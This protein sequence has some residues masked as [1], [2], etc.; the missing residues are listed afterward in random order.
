MRMAKLSPSWGYARIQGAMANLGHKIAPNTVKRL[1]KEHGIEP[2]PFR[3]RR[4]TWA[5]FLR[6][7]WDTLPIS[8]PP[9]S[10]LPAGLVTFY[11]LFA[12]Q[13]K[14]RWVH[15]SIPTPNPDRVFMKQVALDLAA[16][17]DSFLRG[18]SHL[19]I[20]RDSKYTTEFR[21]VLKENDVDIVPIP[22]K[23]PNCNPHA[24]R[25]VRSV[26]QEYASIF[27]LD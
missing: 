24:E 3:R 27:A 20:D 4:T 18:Y 9:K 13:L 5:Q 16:F 26:K 8:S 12:I 14:T 19:I 10:G 11:V 22:T 17:D 25:F 21:E 6:S 2:A 1:L 15:I 7:H 23:S